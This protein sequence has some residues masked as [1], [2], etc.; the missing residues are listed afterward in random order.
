[1]NYNVSRLPRQYAVLHDHD[2]YEITIITRGE[3]IHHINGEN[4]TV[5]SNTAIFLRPWDRH[6]FEGDTSAANGEY[7]NI[8]YTKDVLDRLCQYLGDGF[9]TELLTAPDL[10]PKMHISSE[11]VLSI[12]SSIEALST[13]S[14]PD[15]PARE[16]LYLHSIIA[17]LYFKFFKSAFEVNDIKPHWFGE[18]L[19]S[20]TRPENFRLGVSGFEAL[21]GRSLAYISRLF[22]KQLNTTPTDYFND[23]R[24]RYCAEKLLH[25]D[26]EIISIAL[27]AGFDNLSHFYH[28]FK[29]KYSV[30]PGHYRKLNSTIY[31]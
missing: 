12:Q 16:K 20:I 7:I 9:D 1:M 14:N 29:E 25:S 15:F 6:F 18:L 22:R 27:D 3:F 4:Q 10:P 19:R 24:L 17:E 31:K 23:I 21:S 26:D 13:A 8:I 2:Y 5:S 30:A 28:L 11:D